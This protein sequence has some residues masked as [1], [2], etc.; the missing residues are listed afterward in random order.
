MEFMQGRPT[1]GTPCESPA[2]AAPTHRKR[3]PKAAATDLGHDHDAPAAGGQVLD[4]PPRQRVR[5]GQER[6]ERNDDGLAAFTHEAQHVITIHEELAAQFGAEFDHGPGLVS[7]AF[8][9]ESSSSI[10]C[11]DEGNL[12]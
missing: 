8:N 11:G 6:V 3:W 1:T 9:V 4:H 12:A 5:I 7:G 10:R 2:R